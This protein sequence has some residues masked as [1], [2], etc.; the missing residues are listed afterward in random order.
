MLSV[1]TS[2]FVDSHLAVLVEH[3]PVPAVHQLV[4]R[5][6]PPALGSRARRPQLGLLCVRRLPAIYSERPIAA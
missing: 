1:F 2:F 5:L 3:H 6:L 4:K